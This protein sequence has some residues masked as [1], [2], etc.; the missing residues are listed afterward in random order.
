[1]TAIDLLARRGFLIDYIDGKYCLSDNSDPDD[2]VFL[3]RIL[4]SSNIG[5]TDKD[6]L[7][8]FTVDE[9]AAQAELKKL[10]SPI[11]RG[12]VGVGEC[13]MVMS[14]SY[15]VAKRKKASKVP[16]SWLEANIAAYI[17][18]LSACGIYTGG[19]CDGNHPDTQ[20]LNIQFCYP[21]ADIHKAMWEFHLDSLFDINWNNR[22]DSIGLC[23][24]KEAQYDQLYR[25][26][27]YV[28]QNRK[29]FINARLDASRWMKKNTLKHMS[30][31]DIRNRFRDEF[32]IT[33]KKRFSSK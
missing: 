10:F 11:E 27:K 12:K 3:N 18:A 30:E 14:W 5:F 23:M 29:I 15:H 21:Y 13:C 26:A 20:I 22:Y 7:I 8:N 19:C 24:D 9:N 32:A 17:K 28:Y 31:N 2:L 25:A 1:M 6:G 4:Q 16:V 33:I